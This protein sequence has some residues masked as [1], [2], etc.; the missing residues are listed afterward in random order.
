MAGRYGSITCRKRNCE[1]VEPSRDDA[2][3]PLSAPRRVRARA[4]SG[5][6][7]IGVKP[8]EIVSYPRSSLFWEGDQRRGG[9]D[10]RDVA[11]FCRQDYRRVV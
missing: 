1:R 4:M 6:V 11:N 2:G 7:C 8:R 3:R 5:V 9:L 10:A